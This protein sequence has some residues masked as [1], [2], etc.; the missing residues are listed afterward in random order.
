MKCP[1]CNKRQISFTEFLVHQPPKEIICSNCKA[2]L[3]LSTLHQLYTKP[4][5]GF[6]FGMFFGIIIH[7]LLNQIFKVSLFQEI[8]WIIIIILVII[9]SALIYWKRG[10]L[11]LVIKNSKE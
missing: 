8:A 2:S 4:I 3:K 7:L 6:L 1:K 10:K 9:I 11:I 5:F